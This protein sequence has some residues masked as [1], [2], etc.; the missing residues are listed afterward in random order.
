LVEVVLALEY[1]AVYLLFVVGLSL[2]YIVVQC[3]PPDHVKLDGMQLEKGA[4]ASVV[5]V[6]AAAVVDVQLY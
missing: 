1:Y 5:V 4:A 2:L 6:V 3:S